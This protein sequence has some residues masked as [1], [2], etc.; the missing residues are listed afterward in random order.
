[1]TRVM[2][3][4]WI[5][6]DGTHRKTI[7]ALQA[8]PFK[9]TQIQTYWTTFNENLINLANFYVTMFVDLLEHGSSLPPEKQSGEINQYRLHYRNA[10]IPVTHVF[11]IRHLHSSR[12]NVSLLEE[13]GNSDT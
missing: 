5:P 10:H 9:D 6:T 2:R 1:M 11:L 13:N 3:L 7:P 12:F 8:A 4:P